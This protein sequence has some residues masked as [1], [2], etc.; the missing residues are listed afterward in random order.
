MLL[1]KLLILVTIISG[2][3]I[4]GQAQKMEDYSKNWKKIA[5]LE[6]Q[7]LTTSALKEVNNVFSLALASG[8]EVQQVKS[9]MY[10]MKYRNLVELDNRENNIFY[11]DTL[12][13]KTKAPVKNILQSMQAELFW[14]YRQNNRYRLYNRTML[15]EEKSTDITTWS[16]N[17]LNETIG[18]LY[19]SSLK[20]DGILKSTNLNGLDAILEKGQN[21]RHLRPSL[22]DFLAH[23]ALSYFMDGENDLTKPAYKFILD[24]P[25]IFSSGSEFIRASFKTKDSTSLYYNALLVLQQLLAFHEHDPSPEAFTDVNLLRLQFAYEHG[26]FS[27]KEALYEA[28][29][30]KIETDYPNK[31][32]AALAMSLRASLYYS[33]GQDYDPLT[34]TQHQFE[35][36]KAIALCEQTIAGFPKSDAAIQCKNLMAQ[37]KLPTLNI[38]TEKVNIPGQPFRSMV[39]YKN[40]NKLYL[41]IIKTSREE[42]NRFRKLEHP[43]DWKFIED[44][45]SIKSWNVSLP[46]QQDYQMHRAEIPIEG[47]QNGMYIILAS[48]KPDF[49]A[50]KNIMAREIF[51]VSRNSYIKNTQDEIYVLDRDNGKP[52]PGAIVQV[53]QQTYDY[54][55]R[56]YRYIKK[57]K[58]I[59]SDN[60]LLK[61]KKS[62]ENFNYQLQVQFKGDELFMDE[63]QSSYTYN[64]YEPRTT[65]RSFLFTDRSIYRPG[66]QVFFKGIVVS[67]DSASKK[68]QIVSGYKTSV[69]LYD[70]NGQKISSV[71]LLTNNYGSYNGSFQLPDGLLNGQ[72]YIRDSANGSMQYISVEE[73]KRPAFF[74][75][76]KKPEGTYRLGD[77]IQVKGFAKAYAGNN[78]DGAKVTYRVVRKVRYPVWWGWGGYYSRGKMPY[79]GSG[80]AMEIINGETETA[81]DG[82]FKLSFKAIPDETVDKSSQPIFYYE[83]SADIT[84]LNGESRSGNT[85]VAMAYQMLQLKIN[86]PDR[87]NTD[88]LGKISISSYNL[89]DLY[90]KSSIQISMYAL[91]SPNRLFRERYW[92]M[93][94]QFVM[95]KEAYYASFPYDA[96]Q[97]EDQ[98][99]SWKL[100]N[101]V[102]DISD[103]T[104]ES[105]K[106]SL[107]GK[108]L[109]AGWYKLLVETKDKNGELV[110]AEM[111]V[112]V[113]GNEQTQP[114]IPVVIDMSQKM[115]LPGQ[116][117]QYSIRTAF[118]DVWLIHTLSK[119]DNAS[120]TSYPK[121]SARKPFTN[122][123]A[124]TENDR[125]GIYI[126]YAFI[127]H[128]RVYSGNETGNI[129][130]NNKDLNIRYETFRD[131]LLPG[132]EET[133]K[134]H[135]SGDKATQVAAE[136]LISMYDASLDQ[137]KP[138]NWT[139]LKSLW[140]NTARFI[141]WT[142]FGFDDV[143]AEVLNS[144]YAEA[145]PQKEKTYDELLNNGWSE[146]YGGRYETRYSLQARASGIS[147]EF[148]AA[149]AMINLDGNYDNKEVVV[150]AMGMSKKQKSVKQ[151]VEEKSDTTSIGIVEQ[152]VNNDIKVRKNFNETAFFFPA[153]QTDSAGNISFSFTI[154]E[155]LTSWKLMTLSH[156]TELASGYAEK[157]VITQ[158]PMMLQPN[159]PRFT[160]EGDQIEFSTKI[161]N[162]SDSEITGTAQLELFDA[163]NNKGVDGWFKNIFPV[164]YFTV[165]AGQSTALKFPVEIPI[166]FNS[167]L[168]WRLKAISKDGVFTDGEES[169][170][171]VLTNRMLVTETMPLNMRNSNSKNF[172]FEKLLNSG[173]SGSL[174]NHA[175]TVEYT[176]NPAW[177]AVQ[178][179]PYLMEYPYE[180]AEQTFNRYYA[181]SLAS[182]ISNKMP[183]IRSVFDQWKTLDTAALQSNLQK[184][185]TLKSAL[186]QET[187][188]VL[189]ANNEEA[190]KKN[191][192]LLFDMTKL[193]KEKDITFNKLREMQSGNG[194]FTW[195][196]G[197]PDDR[198]ITQYIITGIGH[199]KK[200]NAMSDD[201]VKKLK[202]LLD[203][204]ILYLDARL[205]DEYDQLVKQ[206]VKLKNNNLSFMAIQYLY[207]RSFFTD[208]K[209]GSNIEKAYGYYRAQTQQYWLSNGKYM[210]A[211]IALSL[212]RTGDIQTAEAII[213][214]L[215]E[216][217]IYQEEMG[218]FWKEF[219][220]G[221]YYWHQAPIESQAMMIEAFTDIDRNNVTIDDL[222]TWL[223]KQKQTQNW[224]TTKATAEACYALL[225]NGSDWLSESKNVRIQLGNHTINSDKKKTEAGT[226]YFKETIPGEQVQ[227]GMGNISVNVMKS[228]DKASSSTSWGAVYWQYFEDLDKITPAETPLK[229]VK[230]LY[231]QK[232][233]DRG[234]QLVLVKDGD[235]LH[236]GDKVIVRIELRADRDMEY[237]HLKD[238][239]AACMEPV[240]VISQY[241]W[242]GGL[243][244][245]ETT[246]DASSNFFFSRMAR[247][248]YVFEYPLFVTHSGN[249]SNG[250]ST[251]QCMYAPE[252]SSHSEGIRI[253]VAAK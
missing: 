133:W 4:N 94:D 60:G 170:L 205:K 47:L 102:I 28:A 239:R 135:I 11:I 59:A 166:N 195:F 26:I 217:A 110:K 140:P 51:Y 101:K 163:R 199:L 208:N 21:S 122:A 63:N 164:Q 56:E 204:A 33:Q 137:F 80:E 248:T 203:K 169:A 23:R 57:E 124:I 160:R 58:Y 120:N 230:K 106:T 7:G 144:M 194:G 105:G 134:I 74:V 9:V 152:P 53:W 115:V 233:S 126:N 196:K 127:Q 224:R 84:D 61:L 193:A 5:S 214:S 211:M 141:S 238:M 103:T 129:P 177:Y 143:S 185:Q 8:N 2:T 162:L 247:G 65:K 202:P 108:S 165:A 231:I 222:K 87:L 46:D 114:D 226:G 139:N 64:S 174:T 219:S 148:A 99:A 69:L 91:K 225:L 153:L 229:L 62:K 88:S 218:M 182:Y 130:W 50:S 41:R 234:P 167:A 35:I 158:K 171:P 96:Y 92:E 200:M 83:V 183:R 190:Q 86:A 43:E 32:S 14:N 216:N 54:E 237:L 181:N 109:P 125:G 223:L 78:I 73:Y 107:S 151:S 3:F 13:A 192:A 90:Q 81:N 89:N 34:K 12:V 18:A 118:D 22:Y 236:I 38:K 66:Q 131:K 36:K 180:C 77:S 1:K 72:F 244:Y 154:P 189:D 241:Q 68:S 44:L 55:A 245:Y 232:N 149:P 228:N 187:P 76:I 104:Q 75:E 16:I 161:V 67:T 184:N 123:L 178:A 179:L 220:T 136:T 112:R 147:N 235:E 150:T 207:M 25:A 213:R 138:H 168:T 85:S 39:E 70:V 132:S 173:N 227:Q 146:S 145:L 240:N 113:Y 82:T 250:I 97:N 210:Q 246:K 249:F 49:S 253:N 175:L 191:I 10:Q 117:L 251:I 6:K 100:E 176:S 71:K 116:S 30:K 201:D 119:Q 24:D 27:N 215:K 98:P 52:L 15:S 197:G 206:K 95:S 159:T 198:Y 221:G 20:N 156:T 128:N 209:I 37:I 42:V 111:F 121:L 188:W 242:K 155:A 19:K 48:S 186:L 29:L 17:K 212:F 157:T 79:P 45:A 142:K 40:V 172:K 31:S 93:P 243:G 252:F